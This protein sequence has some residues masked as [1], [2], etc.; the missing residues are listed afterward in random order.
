[1]TAEIPDEPKNR[2]EQYLAK[3]AG[4]NVPLPADGP[5]NRI[6]MYLNAIVEEGGGGGG[7][8]YTAGTGIE[9]EDKKISVDTDTIQEKLTAG[10]NIAI[11]NNTISATDTTY[12]NF[13]GTDG[14][15]A[16][17]AGLVPAPATTDAGKFL[18][19]DGTWDTASGGGGVTVL[20]AA[21]YNYP[22]NA[23]EEIALW[24]LPVGQYVIDA[25]VKILPTL[26]G[27]TINQG[28][29]QGV[30]VL[31]QKAD[32]AFYTTFI[33]SNFS[34]DKY[35]KVQGNGNLVSGFP[36]DI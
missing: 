35:Y 36:H 18:K 21:D 29:K 31:N 10:T 9:I 2:E 28:F 23:P 3:I 12:S 19:A 25:S 34:D 20:T 5:R 27:S 22:E 8:S 33:L 1:M 32:G 14:T 13:T 15:A 24:M 17:V 30:L 16:G 4:Q 7:G 26:D 11:S 6:E